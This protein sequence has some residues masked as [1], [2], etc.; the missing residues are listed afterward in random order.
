MTK[1]VTGDSLPNV[2]IVQKDKSCE[3]AKPNNRIKEDQSSS[4]MAEQKKDSSLQAQSRS[5]APMTKG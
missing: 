5:F 1:V 3:I 2:T 4:S